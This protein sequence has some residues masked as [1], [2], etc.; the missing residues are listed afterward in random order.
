MFR[1]LFL[2]PRDLGA[3]W[4][5]SLSNTFQFLNNITHIFIHFFTYI[6]LKKYK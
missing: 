3:V 2:C 6:Y 4:Y 1:Y 5:G